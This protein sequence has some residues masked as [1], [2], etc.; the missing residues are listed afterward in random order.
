[1]WYVDHVKTF[2]INLDRRPDRWAEVMAQPAVKK[3]PNL[4]RF[5]GV[6]GKKLNVDTDTRISTLCR[7]NIKNFTRR[8]H[9]ML[10]SIGGVG[11]ALSHIGLWT[12][13]VNSSDNVFLILED[14]ILIEDKQ[15]DN[16]RMLF[17]RD[18]K[19]ADSTTWDIWSLGRIHCLEE[20]GVKPADRNVVEDKWQRCQ[21][22]VGLNA[23]FISRTGAQK[24]LKDVYP[25]QQ[26]IDWYI[27]Y[28]GQ[29]KPFKI[30]HNKL[31]NYLQRGTGSDIAAKDKCI[32]CDVPTTVEKSHYVLPIA[33][34]NTTVLAALSLAFVI[35]I[36]VARKS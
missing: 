35:W 30:I 10:D 33:S 22:F 19:L 8:S 5:P 9:D 26:H 20:M 21:Q 34:T 6:D 12:K 11:C 36:A 25:I 31:V 4:E 32:I 27:T 24:L 1:M 2:C 14:D 18:P 13:L 23:Y 7:Y 17:A 28:Y 3:F 29:T 15:W 16:V